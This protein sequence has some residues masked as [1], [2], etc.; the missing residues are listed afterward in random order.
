MFILTFIA[1]RSR[2]DTPIIFVW[3][4]NK[5]RKLC[6][7]VNSMYRRQRVD[8]LNFCLFHSHPPV[9]KNPNKMFDTSM[10][11]ITRAGC[12]AGGLALSIT[13]LIMYSC[14]QTSLHEEALEGVR[15]TRCQ[16]TTETYTSVP[17]PGLQSGSSGLYKTVRGSGRS[18]GTVPDTLSFSR[19]SVLV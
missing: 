4:P 8:F 3:S 16:G 2:L 5:Q 19:T 10:F 12:W 15:S 6:F 9:Q 1:D 17:L 13:C 7:I 14:F 18:T 11:V